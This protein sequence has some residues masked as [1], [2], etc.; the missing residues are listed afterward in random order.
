MRFGYRR[1][2]TRLAERMA[3][4][5]VVAASYQRLAQSGAE[6]GTRQLACQQRAG[7]A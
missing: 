4:E 5:I 1:P 3:K 6:L 7:V 2:K